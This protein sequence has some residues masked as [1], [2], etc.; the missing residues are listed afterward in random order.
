MSDFGIYINT[1][2]DALAVGKM[3]SLVLHS[4]LLAYEACVQI[5]QFT[6]PYFKFWNLMRSQFCSWS[7]KLEDRYSSLR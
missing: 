3:P 5:K 4:V 2:S 1:G 7:K 6:L